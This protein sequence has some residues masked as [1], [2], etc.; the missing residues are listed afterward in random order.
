[1]LKVK[2][3]ELKTCDVARIDG[4]EYS[5]LSVRTTCWLNENLEQTRSSTTVLAR[6]T[7]TRAIQTLH[8]DAGQPCLVI[9]DR[10]PG[11]PLNRRV[12]G[13]DGYTRKMVSDQIE[14]I[15]AQ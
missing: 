9:S 2:A 4:S 6:N 3:S 12:N 11:L 15:M 14:R 8:V 7:A 13:L 10:N 5:V 1:M